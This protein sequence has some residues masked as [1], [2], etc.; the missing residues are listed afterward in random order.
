LCVRG[1]LLA[2]ASILLASAAAAEPP[3]V[4]TPLAPRPLFGFDSRD[5]NRLQKADFSLSLN[6]TN[7]KDD[8][9]ALERELFGLLMQPA[10]MS[11]GLHGILSYRRKM[12]RMTVA[13]DT[14]S[15]LQRY[16]QIQ[17]TVG[18][19]GASLTLRVP[20]LRRTELFA[21]QRLMYLQSYRLF[22]FPDLSADAAVP[23]LGSNTDAAVSR[24]K[25]YTA[26][27]NVGLTQT[28]SRRSSI[29]FG[30]DFQSIQFSTGEADLR[31]WGAGGRF[32][33]RLT[34]STFLR[35]GYGQRLGQYG[36]FSPGQ[37]TRMQ[38]SGVGIDY[39]SPRRKPIAISVT[40]GST[41]V[42]G[43][44]LV[45]GEADVK[46]YLSRSWS[47]RIRY[48]R[49]PEFVGGF[50]E[51]VDLDSATAGVEGFVGR[52]LELS[53]SAVYSTG[54]IGSQATY[55][56]YSGSAVASFAMNRRLALS[57]EYLYYSHRF[58]GD[59]TLPAAASLNRHSVR[60]GIRWWTPLR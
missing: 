38:D 23:V 1:C 36:G 8:G 51:P 18:D 32:T 43:R 42:V 14:T 39:E 9:S 11:S 27:T 34:R 25:A 56:S 2:I 47:A 57:L 45:T 26:T 15:T 54:E 40:S 59:I 5:P 17:D 29:D 49:R 16:E 60:A 37:T 19:H 44:V 55:E 41:L 21:S 58:A 24:L 6:V 28:L 20:L 48:R 52:R 10:G 7:D 35:F 50:T 33:R 3:D 13:A 53:T 31:T 12:K 30:Y 46:Q 22:A 4:A